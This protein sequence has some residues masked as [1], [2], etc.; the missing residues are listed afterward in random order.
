MGGIV[1]TSG[2]PCLDTAAI[3]RRHWLTSHRRGVI[4]LLEAE[5]TA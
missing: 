3:H 5:P 1:E 4:G 2:Q